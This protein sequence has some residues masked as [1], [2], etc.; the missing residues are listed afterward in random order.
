LHR[1]ASQAGAQLAQLRTQFRDGGPY[2]YDFAKS[3]AGQR[4]DDCRQQLRPA[5][6]ELDTESR[7]H[8]GQY[9]AKDRMH[10][11][12]IRPRATL[13]ARSLIDFTTRYKHTAPE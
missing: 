5:A 1:R 13:L 9:D 10:V 6:R 11:L 12:S 2:V 4:A 8:D 7:A 3:Q